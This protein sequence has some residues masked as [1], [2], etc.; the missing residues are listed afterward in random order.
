MRL[1]DMTE[2]KM[3]TWHEGLEVILSPG[4]YRALSS[5]V[6]QGDLGQDPQAQGQPDFA[7]A[8]S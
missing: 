6:T 5:Q 3:W 7:S 4:L 1:E 2:V 8:A